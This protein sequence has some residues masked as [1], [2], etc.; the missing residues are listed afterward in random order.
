MK[1]VS[2]NDV[3][4]NVDADGECVVS[5]VFRDANDDRKVVVERS[6]D[7]SNLEPPVEDL[8]TSLQQTIDI[9]LQGQHILTREDLLDLVIAQPKSRREVLSELLNLPDIDDRR[10]A[11]QRTRKAL[12]DKQDNAKA[13]RDTSRERL[14]ELTDSRAS[15]S[16]GLQKDALETINELRESFDG[17]SVEEIN[18][19][20]VREDLESPLD[21]IST[22]ALQRERPQEELEHF[23][24]WLNDLG[25]DTPDRIGHLAT[26]FKE[27]KEK[28]SSEVSAIRLELLELGEE[29]IAPGAEV[30][31]LC[32][33]D[34]R[35]DDPLIDDVRQRREQLR[36]LQELLED[37]EQTQDD[38]QKELKRG[39]DYLEYLTKELADDEYP[40]SFGI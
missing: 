26:L 33:Q 27:Y 31:P 17:G 9:A 36:E 18:P 1:S 16:V 21:A 28:E 20:T 8:P 39:S 32:E 3:I 15:A 10:L 7:S 13:S 23:S 38:L 37:I 14:Q 2:K 22:Q 29:V 30:C 40:G 19:E 11:L 25:A 24:E 5:G 6:I 34:W 12:E 35:G 4:P